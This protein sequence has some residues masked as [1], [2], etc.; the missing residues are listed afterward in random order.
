VISGARKSVRPAGV[1]ETQPLHRPE[2][3]FRLRSSFESAQL[4]FLSFGGMV[5][6]LWY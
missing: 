4:S 5:A 2:R 1:A 3:V 6:Y